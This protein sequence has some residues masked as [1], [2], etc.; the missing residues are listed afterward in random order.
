MIAMKSL[1]G[2]LKTKDKSQTMIFLKLSG[3][4][5]MVRISKDTYGHV[6]TAVGQLMS[7]PHSLSFPAP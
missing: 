1:L 4:L 3:S 7:I 2:H 6:H 5:E